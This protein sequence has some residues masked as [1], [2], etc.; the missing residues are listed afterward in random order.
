MKAAHP[1][2]EKIYHCRFKLSFGEWTREE[3]PPDGGCDAI[4]V[5]SIIRGMEPHGGS[6]STAFMSQDGYTGKELTGT[7]LFRTWGLLAY[8]LSQRPD[9]PAWQREVVASVHDQIKAVIAPGKGA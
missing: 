8:A 6:V 3:L 4:L 1:V 7:E 2:S 9:L 5:A